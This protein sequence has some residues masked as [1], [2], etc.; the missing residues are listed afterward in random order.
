MERISSSLTFMFKWAFPL[1]WVGGLLFFVSN[2]ITTGA[3]GREPM[4]LLFAAVMLGV[5]ILITKKLVW[6][7]AD[8]V[9]DHGSYLVVRRY[10]KEVTIP[11]SNVMNVSS[12][13]FT[14]PPRVTLRLIEPCELG[15]EVS[16]SPKVPFLFNP[17]AKNAVA[18][19]LIERTFRAR[20]KL[21]TEDRMGRRSP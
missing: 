5:G 18:E 9:D 11:L 4:L 15:A 3:V 17:F 12:T 6:D 8:S 16:F 7:L 14:N 1:A 10:G 13:T 2:A 19:G 21:A 20:S